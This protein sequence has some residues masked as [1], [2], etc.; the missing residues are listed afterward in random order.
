MHILKPL[1]FAVAVALQASPVSAADTLKLGAS[2]VSQAVETTPFTKF[3][4]ERVKEQASLQVSNQKTITFSPPGDMRDQILVSM[5]AEESDGRVVSISTSIQHSFMEKPS[6][7]ATA[8]QFIAHLLSATLPSS[9]PDEL[10]G[11]LKELTGEARKGTPHSQA[12]EAV[13]G[14]RPVALLKL[15]PYSV[16]FKNYPAQGARPASLAVAIGQSHLM[17]RE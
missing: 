3:N 12:F 17:F 11:L 5:V 7:A 8:H 6:G 9:G 4:L 14:K 2:T 15:G 13:L 1:V 10:R 16:V